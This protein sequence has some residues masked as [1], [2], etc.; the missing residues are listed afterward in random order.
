MVSITD[1]H[2]LNDRINNVIALETKNADIIW[3]NNDI[4]YKY[5]DEWI[6]GNVVMFCCCHLV[7]EWFKSDEQESYVY[8]EHLC[9]ILTACQLDYVGV[10]GSRKFPI[11]LY[12]PKPLLKYYIHRKCEILTQ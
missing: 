11:K 2:Y 12:E 8:D 5:R 9:E 3:M 4:D 6:R 10:N 7:V 1:L